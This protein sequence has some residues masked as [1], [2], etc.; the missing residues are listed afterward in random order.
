MR[1][2][3]LSIVF[4]LFVACS[5]VTPHDAREIAYQ[6]LSAQEDGPS[7]RGT[8]LRTALVVSGQ[9]DGNFLVELRDEPRNLLWAVIVHP[10]GESETT[11][12]AIDG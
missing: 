1:K 4:L 3:I 7:L 12:M 10:S 6:R 8:A 5:H 11:K 2:F 9:D